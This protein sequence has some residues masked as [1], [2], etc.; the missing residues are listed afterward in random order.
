[1]KPLGRTADGH[2][3]FAVDSLKLALPDRARHFHRV[4]AC[5]R[6]GTEIIEWERAVHRPQD[7]DAGRRERLCDACAPMPPEGETD[8]PDPATSPALDLPD[9]NPHA[10]ASVAEAM[11]SASGPGPE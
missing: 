10:E 7:L 4:L 9:V 2:P 1:V 6:C 11:D 8:D 5:S 3:L